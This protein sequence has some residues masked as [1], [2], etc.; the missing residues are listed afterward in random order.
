MGRWAYIHNTGGQTQDYKFWFG[1]QSSLHEDKYECGEVS[2]GH[3][4]YFSDDWGDRDCWKTEEGKKYA[5]IIK[6]KGL[7]YSDGELNEGEEGF[8]ERDA[9]RRIMKEC[10]LPEEF[11][12][13]YWDNLLGSEDLIEICEDQPE[14]TFDYCDHTLENLEKAFKVGNI[15]DINGPLDNRIIELLG[16]FPCE[17]YD[18]IE[19][20]W[21]AVGGGDDDEQSYYNRMGKNNPED[22]NT[23]AEDCSNALLAKMIW[24]TMIIDECSVDI[25]YEW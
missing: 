11:A 1:T 16:E 10:D 12:N 24:A 15:G 6:A 18:E 21:H 17:T 7:C 19:T 4:Y 3:L 9:C 5:D 22:G 20:M 13:W 2:Q 14:I 23:L 8:D 25:T